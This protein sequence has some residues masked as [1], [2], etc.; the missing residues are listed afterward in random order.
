MTGL[1]ASGV[2][3]LRLSSGW[4]QPAET[5]LTV[6]QLAH[7]MTDDAAWSDPENAAMVVEIQL[8]ARPRNPA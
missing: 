6:G 8:R 2:V 3:E 7:I 4:P 1:L 5:E